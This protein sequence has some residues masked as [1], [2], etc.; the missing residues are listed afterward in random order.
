M[1]FSY[2]LLFTGKTIA[3][4]KALASSGSIIAYAMMMTVSPTWTRCA[5]ATGNCKRIMARNAITPP[6]HR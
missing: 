5:A 4:L 3:G 1:F 6:I 2:N